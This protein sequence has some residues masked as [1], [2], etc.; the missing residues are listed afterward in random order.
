MRTARFLVIIAVALA[1]GLAVAVSPFAS[2]SPDGLNKVAEDKGFS[3]AGRLHQVQESSPIEGYAFPGIENDRVAKGV[4]GL[5]GTLGVFAGGY[6]VAA[7]LRRRD[8]PSARSAAAD[9]GLVPGS[10][11]DPA[12]CVR[13]LDPRAKVVGI[14]A[15]HAGRGCRSCS[16]PA[17][18]CST[19]STG[20]S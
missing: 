6:G 11:A 12:S 8:T 3:D 4:A 10:P 18:R 1:V 13:R 16:R 7:L 14:L 15:S 5:A 17:C 9:L 20:R 19:R 2:S